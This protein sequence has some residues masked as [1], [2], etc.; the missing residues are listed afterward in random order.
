MKKKIILERVPPPPVDPIYSIRWGFYGASLFFPF[1]GIII[2]LFLFEKD[3]LEVRRVGR[4]CLLL[5]F[6]LWV[7]FPA[8]LLVV[9]LVFGATALLGAFPDLA[10]LD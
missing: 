8:F 10:S 3:S 7:L 9:L 4:N 2:A 5:S 6:L 1:A